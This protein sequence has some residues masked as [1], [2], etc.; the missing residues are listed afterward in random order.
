MWEFRQLQAWKYETATGKAVS[1]RK[2][3]TLMD[4][5]YDD[6]LKGQGIDREKLRHG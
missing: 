3:S 2:D 6:W 5:G 4:P 1:D